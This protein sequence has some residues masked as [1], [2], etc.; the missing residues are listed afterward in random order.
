M[1]S[2]EVITKPCSCCKQ[3]KTS[4]MF[5]FDKSKKTG[6]SSR[7]KICVIERSVIQRT[8]DPVAM[9]KY[10]AEH[11]QKNKTKI[12]QKHKEYNKK[13]AN[14]ISFNKKEYRIKNKDNLLHKRRIWKRNKMGKLLFVF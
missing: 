4:D 5:Y 2:S 13:N 14:R 3:V 7:C 6:L 10:K 12:S 11:Y 8:S 9:K 1:E